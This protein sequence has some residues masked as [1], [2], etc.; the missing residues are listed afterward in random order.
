MYVSDVPRDGR[1]YIVVMSAGAV[2]CALR[3]GNLSILFEH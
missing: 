1:V 3:V 2:T